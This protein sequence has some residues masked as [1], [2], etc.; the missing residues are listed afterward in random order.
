[1]II[2]NHHLPR[3]KRVASRLLSFDPP[4]LFSCDVELRGS[5]RNP[6]SVR[7]GFINWIGK[8]KRIGEKLKKEVS[9]RCKMGNGVVEGYGLSGPV[10][11]TACVCPPLS[12]DEEGAGMDEGS[13]DFGLPSTPR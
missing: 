1:M 13:R 5:W 10:L 8:S 12:A 4:L 11:V 9:W 2:V 7:A 3:L 6:E